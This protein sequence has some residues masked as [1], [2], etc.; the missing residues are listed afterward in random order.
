MKVTTQ[1]LQVFS[2]GFF[3]P[4]NGDDSTQLISMLIGEE[5]PLKQVESEVGPIVVSATPTT[6]VMY[7]ISLGETLITLN[8][9][10]THNTNRSAESASQA[11][12]RF[13]IN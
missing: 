5:Q 7:I 10:N 13:N 11:R 4:S 2:L 6:T 1:L 8:C 9:L 12:S 3:S